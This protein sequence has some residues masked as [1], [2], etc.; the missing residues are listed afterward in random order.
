MID[1]A[2][3]IDMSVLRKLRLLFDQF[4]KKHN[5]VL[6]GQRELLY[7]LSMAINEDFKTRITFSEN[8]LPL[9][10]DDMEEYIMKELEAAR[11]GA[12]TFD[13]AAIELILR[14]AQGNLRLCRNLAYGSLI[15]TCRDK[16]RIVSIGHVNAVL[17]QPHWRTHDELVKQQAS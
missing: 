11:L 13:P 9:N 2:H 12:N 8:I 5:L 16:K 4:P 17:I 15:E 14:S 6:L 3:L 1:E 10:D 7:S